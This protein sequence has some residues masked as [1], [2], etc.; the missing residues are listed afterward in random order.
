MKRLGAT[1][2]MGHDVGMARAEV[3]RIPYGRGNA[4]QKR[5]GV[6]AFDRYVPPRIDAQLVSKRP[7]EITAVDA[8]KGPLVYSYCSSS[9]R[10]IC[11]TDK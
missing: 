6:N 10:S 1:Y 5:I 9:E 8:R 11:S 7:P 2:N 3:L 4:Q